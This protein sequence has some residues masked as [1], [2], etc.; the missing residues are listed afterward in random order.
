[1]TPIQVTIGT[2]RRLGQSY[3]DLLEDLDLKLEELAACPVTHDA[4][5]HE[6]CVVSALTPKRIGAE[7]EAIV[8][9]YDYAGIVSEREAAWARELLALYLRELRAELEKRLPRRR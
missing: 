4:E 1:M 9:G 8:A 5:A 7:L 2:T 3:A 6:A